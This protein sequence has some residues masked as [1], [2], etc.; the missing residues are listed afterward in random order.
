MNDACDEVLCRRNSTLGDAADDVSDAVDDTDYRPHHRVAWRAVG[1]AW[2]R[3]GRGR[4][5]RIG[6]GVAQ[7]GERFA[8]QLAAHLREEVALFLRD[9]VAYVLDQNGDLGI[10]TLARWIEVNEL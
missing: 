7:I 8:T 2:V 6:Q 3:M 5:F 10:E 4:C 1:G 9:V